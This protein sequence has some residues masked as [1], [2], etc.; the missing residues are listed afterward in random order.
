MS[1][2]T[3]RFTGLQLDELVTSRLDGLDIATRTASVVDKGAN[4]H[5]VPAD[6]LAPILIGHLAARHD[7]AVPAP[8]HGRDR[9]AAIM[10]LR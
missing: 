9:R 7:R 3:F 10:P 2:A 8:R 6:I 4:Q 1:F 5:V